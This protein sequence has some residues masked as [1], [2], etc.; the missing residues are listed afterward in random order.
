MINPESPEAKKLK[1]WYDSEGKVTSMSSIGSMMSPS[2]KNGSR[3]MYTDR[4][5]LSHITSNPSLGEDKVLKHFNLQSWTKVLKYK[6]Y[7]LTK[8]LFFL[9]LQPV[10]FSTRGYIS[11]IKPDQT[12]WYQ[13]C[14][15]CNK[16]VT[17]AMDS[18]YWCEGC[19]KKDEECSL[20]LETQIH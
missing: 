16:K 8:N 2:A 18:G 5:S 15:T 7:V 4:V 3:S 10:F 19:Q 9:L 13:A 20:R 1:S 12:M 17:E 6:S 14:K 11:F